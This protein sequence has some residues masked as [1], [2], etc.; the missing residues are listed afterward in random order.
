[1]KCRSDD[2]WIM[3]VGPRRRSKWTWRY[4]LD[5]M[6]GYAGRSYVHLKTG[7]DSAQHNVSIFSSRHVY[8]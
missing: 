6:H 7:P 1:M 8:R 2:H 3:R 4:M 5:D